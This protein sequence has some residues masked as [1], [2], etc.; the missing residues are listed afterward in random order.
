MLG[1]NVESGKVT[2]DP[3]IPSWWQ[4]YSVEINTEHLS[5]CV[6]VLNPDGRSEG[7]RSLT[8]AEK[9]GV[10]ASGSE[11]RVVM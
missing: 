11:I 6:K 7:V 5:C 8:A 10:L 1:I 4:E 2:V 3:R 9:E